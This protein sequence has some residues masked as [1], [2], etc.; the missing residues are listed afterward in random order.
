MLTLDLQALRKKDW[1]LKRFYNIPERDLGGWAG[2]YQAPIPSREC[3]D[4]S[5]MGRV[6]HDT[7]HK[8]SRDEHFLLNLAAGQPRTRALFRQVKD[9]ADSIVG[10]A[11]DFKHEHQ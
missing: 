10:L 11:V 4:E 8:R 5:R 7:R 3:L 9:D 1:P 6:C 2:E